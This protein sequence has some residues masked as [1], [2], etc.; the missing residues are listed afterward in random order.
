MSFPC[1]CSRFYMCFCVINSTFLCFSYF[2]WWDRNVNFFH[3]ERKKT[4]RTS[5]EHELGLQTFFN[6]QF[7]LNQMKTFRTFN[8]FK[9]SGYH[10]SIAQSLSPVIFPPYS[11]SFSSSL[12]KNYHPRTE[13][14]VNST[15]SIFGE[16]ITLWES[17]SKER[18]T[19]TILF[20]LNFGASWRGNHLDFFFHSLASSL[21]SREMRKESEHETVTFIHVKFI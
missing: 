20:E 21:D 3:F 8:T 1:K 10:S 4:F 7:W 17:I 2:V 14:K 15:F 16:L 12:I 18:R 6:I 9:V 13:K 11:L 5:H 19:M